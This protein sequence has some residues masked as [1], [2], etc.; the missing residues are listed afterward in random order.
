MTP[1]RT[2]GDPTRRRRKRRARARKHRSRRTLIA[3][4]IGLPVVIL[5]AGTVGATAVFGSSCN[6]NSLQP[7]AVGQNSFVYASD[8]S[9]LGVIPAE[10]NR[11]PVSR[12][13]I[14][15]WVP[16]ATVAIEDR[17]FYQHGGVDPV[18]IARALVAD[19]RAGRFAQGGSTITQELVR[20]LYLS[21]ERTLQRKLTEACL[22]IK[23]A[24]QWSKNKILTAYMNQV[25]YG[26]H[27]YGIEA[28][29]ETYFS[30]PAKKLNLE[31]SALIAGLPQAP[32]SYDPFRNPEAALDRRN[33]VL[34]AMLVNGNITSSQYETAIAS[35]SLE[36]KPGKRFQRI[37]EPYFF[38][39]VEELLQNEYGSNTVREGG[40]K[41]YTTINPALQRAATS[42]ITHVLNLPT[43]PASAIV[44]IDPRTGAIRAMTAVTPGRRGN[45]F[46][47]VTSARRQ[48]GSTFKT[49]AL[50]TAVSRGMDP[51]TT[52]YLSA[53]FHYQPDSTCNPN[54]PNCAWNVQTY[55]HDYHGV[56]S[57]ESATVQ[58]DNTV[59]A[60]LS[61][62]VGPANIVAMARKLGIRSSPLQ[63]VPSLALGSIGVTPLEMAS[64]YATLAAGGVYSKPM[65]IT[66]VVLPNGKADTSA[67][68]G[69]PQRERVIPDW[70]ASTVTQV[71]EQNMLYG[72]GTGAHVAN[73]TDAGKSGTTDNY[74]DAWFNG[75]TPRLQAAVW[76]GYPSGE[77]PMLDVHGI[78]VSGPSFPA[79]IWHLYMETA[80]GNRKDVPFPPAKTT[81]Q[82]TSW[83][84]QY[85]YS[86][87]YGAYGYGTSTPATTGATT[88]AQPTRSSHTTA[89]PPTVPATTAPPPVTTE[90]PPPPTQP[91]TTST[92]P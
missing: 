64:A 84:G 65:A 39:Y 52:S 48:P 61:L 45:Q 26:N 50:T 72:T 41:V 19:I 22:A 56:E 18:G 12:S 63:A 25:F 16:E 38:S 28:A 15:P 37:R 59:Y 69:K 32:S 21:R 77:I 60:R 67:N 80:I 49:I 27:A 9:E 8:G 54:D 40:L 86:G 88:T 42:A 1:P 87:A 14:S 7:V 33:E 74:A 83:R 34:H 29:A 20:N 58:S 76:I 55:A 53:P 92:T 10:R 89:P 70:V 71:L 17:R 51:F 35:K 43:D 62:D 23:L 44:S 82:W 24:R 81:P 75:Y 91:A 11:T 3:V 5:V 73:H 2:Y 68:W 90:A 66:K 6:L 78:A 36:L 79:Q 46:N 30:L 85:E 4:L 47:F 57:V 31:Q 13:Q